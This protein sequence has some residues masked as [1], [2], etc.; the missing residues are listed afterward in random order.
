MLRRLRAEYG[1]P[2]RPGTIEPVD[3]LV[4]TILSQ[5]TSD[6]NTERAFASLRATFP[7]WEAVIAASD[8]AVA[9]AI[10]SGGLANVK[11]PRI[12]KALADVR[13]RT[14]GFDLSFLADLSVADARGWL[15]S[16][17]GVG[18]KTASCVLLFSLDRP[19]MP[20][21]THVH[22]V[23][24]RL[25]LIP[26]RTSAER[27][28]QMLE[29]IVPDGDMYAA[30][31]LLIRHGRATCYARWP[32]CRSCILVQC[33]PAAQTFLSDEQEQHDG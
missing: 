14:G 32:R 11:A 31:L 15:T 2:E 20:V 25:G 4:M 10:R 28:H 12:R 13:E 7:T 5:H 33:C 6:Q 21:D 3:E 27:A 30:H 1:E 19:A 29:A 24:L 17:D 26:A 8:D 18:P 22:R 16:L 23:S 9:D